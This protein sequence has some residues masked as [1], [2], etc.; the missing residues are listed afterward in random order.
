MLIK[1]L[2]KIGLCLLGGLIL[3]FLEPSAQMGGWRFLV[4]PIYI[5]GIS[6]GVSTALPWAGKAIGSVLKMFMA[7][8]IFKSLIGVILL[9]IFFPLFLAGVLTVG[10]FIGMVKLF[11]RMSEILQ[12]EGGF[13]SPKSRLRDRWE[14]N[15]RRT[16]ESREQLPTDFDDDDDNWM[17]DDGSDYDF[18]PSDDDDF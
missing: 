2:V 12:L 10:W 8:I 4:M 15:R 17:E 6:Y 11:Q 9:V 7:S 16:P 3:A 18:T 5:L 1:E 13:S 14:N